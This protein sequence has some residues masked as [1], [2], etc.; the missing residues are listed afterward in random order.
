[1]RLKLNNIGIIEKAEI[2]FDG[3]TVIAGKNDSGKSTIGKLLYSLIKT[4]KWAS[5]TDGLENRYASKFDKF[6]TSLFKNQI[7]KRGKISFEYNDFS[8]DID[9]KNNHC[10]DFNYPLN[11]VNKE[12]KTTSPLLIETP[13]IW[14][15]LPSLKTIRNLESHGNEI[16]FE[17]SETLKDLH[18]ALTIKLKESDDKVKLDIKPIINGNFQENSLG[19]FVFQ[20][21]N[22]NIELINTAMGIK[23]FGIFQVLSDKN[24]FYNGQVLILDEPEVH[25]HP[26]WQLK[27]AELIVILVQKGIK[28]LVNSH[29]PYMIEALEKYAKIAKIKSDFYLAEDTKIEKIENS[30]SRTLSAIFEKLSEPYDIFEN[31]E[32][33]RFKNG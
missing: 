10:I 29:S 25:L 2:N 1:M 23:Y 19:D 11:Y 12:I 6:I 26:T 28:I 14:S 17:L 27:L 5:N 13:Y 4:I 31:M 32:S 8:F 9:I 15:I 21:E 22:E 30:N 20:K 3:L 18:F 24:H 16:D 33:D 7:S